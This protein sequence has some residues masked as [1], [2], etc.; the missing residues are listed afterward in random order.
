MR[1]ILKPAGVVLLVG[2]MASLACITFARHERERLREIPEAPP[3]DSFQTRKVKRPPKSVFDGAD[4]M[5]PVNLSEAGPL[6]WV[7][8]GDR[9]NAAMNRKAG[10]E[11]VIGAFETL[12]GGGVLAA[13]KRG[14]SRA[15]LWSDGTP[16]LST[17]PTY[18]GAHV[19]AKDGFKLTV[20]AT[21]EERTL[22]VFVGGWKALPNFSAFVSDGSQPKVDV[23]DV[24]LGSGY[25]S[26]TY[27]VTFSAS[28]PGQKLNVVWR[29][30]SGDGNISLQGAALR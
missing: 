1:V 24:A 27:R 6:D 4:Q 23:K 8:W 3:I 21:G 16:E 10:V 9:G 29:M 13:G 20:P 22:F 11:P 7:H 25:Y 15:F 12:K 17:K 19:G 5:K 2:A 28:T 14:P 26:R 30:E 18:S